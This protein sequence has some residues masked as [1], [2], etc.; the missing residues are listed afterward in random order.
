MS[1]GL[2]GAIN[3]NQTARERAR[4]MS[5]KLYRIIRLGKRDGHAVGNADNGTE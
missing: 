5:D 4:Y 2:N 3:E 1:G